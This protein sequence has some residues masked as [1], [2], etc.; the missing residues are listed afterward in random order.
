MIYTI[1]NEKVKV[2]ITDK[3][4]ELQSIILKA[5]G[6][7]YLWQGDAKYWAGRAY[8]LFPI[9]GRLVDGKYT[10]GG[11][12]Y[13]MNLH[14]FARDNVFAVEKASATE[15]T[16]KLVPTDVIRAQYPFEFIFCITYTLT[17][18]CIK[19]GFYVKNVGEN[20]MYF[21]IGGHPGFNVPLTDGE[22]FEDYYLEF[23]CVKPAKK[24]VFTPFFNTGKTEAAQF[25]DGKMIDL[26]H[27]MF[28]DDAKFYTDI[29]HYVTLKSRKCDKSVRVEFPGMQN[30]GFWHAKESDAPYICIEP[31]CSIPGMDGKISDL[32]EKEQMT[33]LAKGGEYTNEFNIII[34]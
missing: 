1:E 28:D 22:K 2:E 30:V 5:D 6:T 14:G 4:A 27:R 32:T 21:A 33:C 7:E 34:K 16:F 25:K 12:E 24:Y 8:N 9:C 11:K 17:D 3:G 26:D 18:T 29:C 20:D 19:T 15:I 13:E 10:Y 31:W 23:D